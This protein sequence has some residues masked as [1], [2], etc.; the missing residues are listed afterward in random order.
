MPEKEQK[1]RM[2]KGNGQATMLLLYCRKRGP[3]EHALDLMKEPYMI[4]E[5]KVKENGREDAKQLICWF[6]C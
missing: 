1:F 4:D 6:D 2:R 3:Q 5:R